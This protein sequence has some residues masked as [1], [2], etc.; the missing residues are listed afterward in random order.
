MSN[1]IGNNINMIEGEKN[2]RKKYA[3]TLVELIAVIV[4]LAIILAIS[5]F[6]ISKLIDYEKQ[7]AF[8][9]S[10]Q[11]ILKGVNQ[12]KSE[13]EK[14]EPTSVTENNIMSLLNISD[15]NYEFIEIMIVDNKLTIIIIGK[16]KWNGLT[17]CGTSNNIVIDD[18]EYCH[19]LVADTLV[20]TISPESA[21]SGSGNGSYIEKNNANYFVGSNPNNWLE[22]GQVSEENETPILWRIIKTDNNGLKIVY[23]GTKNGSNPLL[24]DGNIGQY[25]WNNVVDNKWEST[26]TIV[27][28]LNNWYENFYAA[29]KNYY[30]KPIKWCIG[31]HGSDN[32]NNIKIFECSDRNTEGGSFLGLT[33]NISSVGLIN[34]S[35]YIS[36]SSSNSCYHTDHLACGTNNFLL[37][38]NYNWWTINANSNS[39]SSTWY[40]STN[41]QIDFG[42]VTGSGRLLRP[43][44][45][46][47]KFVFYN[48]GD[49]SLNNPYTIK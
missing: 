48:S 12:K 7:K 28:T 18:I 37:K 30:L 17:A 2:M 29:N 24:N 6:A 39:S 22:F 14:F 44:L 10:A 31:G 34:T 46:L 26:A 3:F 13:E 33:T 49:G 11:M 47:K 15:N 36:T 27:A 21:N 23:E 41:G 16:N 32:I 20:N 5:V 38:S 1:K 25:P 40:V 8:S 45:N 42:I 9:I 4:I 43:V 19:S 35:D